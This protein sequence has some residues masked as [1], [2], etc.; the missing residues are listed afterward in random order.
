MTL[1]ISRPFLSCC[2]QVHIRVIFSTACGWF[3]IMFDTDIHVSHK[4]NCNLFGYALMLKV[5]KK[6]IEV[7]LPLLTKSCLWWWKA[8]LHSHHL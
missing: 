7:V 5:E 3:E 6:H 8:I 1:V 4:M 2:Q